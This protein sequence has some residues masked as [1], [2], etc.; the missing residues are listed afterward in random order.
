MNQVFQAL[1][2]IPGIYFFIRY[3]FDVKEATDNLMM[4]FSVSALIGVIRIYRLW[5]YLPLDFT[6]KTVYFIDHGLMIANRL[7]CLVFLFN[8]IIIWG[9]HK[10]DYLK[11][12]RQTDILNID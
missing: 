10:A 5:K 6:D 11:L 3:E 8:A 7:I 12:M 9:M 4:G 2:L 1:H